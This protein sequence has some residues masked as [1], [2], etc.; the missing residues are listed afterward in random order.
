MMQPVIRPAGE[1]VPEVLESDITIHV[2]P[3]RRWW[4]P[5]TWL[6]PEAFNVKVG[7]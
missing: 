7:G 5:I 6:L 2:R 4:L 1:G 3:R